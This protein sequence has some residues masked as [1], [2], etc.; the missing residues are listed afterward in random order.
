MRNPIL[1]T[2]DCLAVMQAMEEDSV[3]LVFGS[4]PYEDARTYGI[5][6]KLRGQDWVD[7]MAEVF[8]ASLRVSKGVVGFVVEGRTRKFQWSA[9]PALLMADLH[10]AGIELRKPPLY[11]RIGIPGSGGPDWWK[12]NYEFIICA[13]SGRLP[14]SNNIACGHPPKYGPG[15]PPSHRKQ[16][17]DRVN[18]EPTYTRN[19]RPSGEVEQRA[20]KPPKIANPGNVIFVMAGADTWGVN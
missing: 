5:D 19:R 17:G 18:G 10:R 4:P 3:D 13:S 8:K 1:V 7:W 16:N 20:Y 12:N 15:G 14:W 9:T 11:H 2:G 6:F